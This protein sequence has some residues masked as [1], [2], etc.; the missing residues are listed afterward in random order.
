MAFAADVLEQRQVLPANFG[1]QSP[2]DTQWYNDASNGEETGLNQPCA[3]GLFPEGRS[4]HGCHDMAGNI[5]KWRSTLWGEDMA[6]PSYCYSW[7]DDG[8]EAVKATPELRCVLR[9]GCFSSGRM[10][11]NCTYCGSLE[12]SGYWRGNGFRVVVARC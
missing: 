11:A 9:A 12:P 8:R 3:V 1:S 5:W 4:P 7:R 10:K 2:W 6:I